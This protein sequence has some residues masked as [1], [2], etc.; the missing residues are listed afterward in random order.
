MLVV[1]PSS[2]AGVATTQHCARGAA[3]SP[4]LTMSGEGMCNLH[5]A[6]EY[7]DPIGNHTVGVCTQMSTHSPMRIFKGH[8][9]AILTS[10]AQMHPVAH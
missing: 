10:N 3:Y 8:F 6:Q 9:V 4:Q 7:T 2:C 5:A 1:G